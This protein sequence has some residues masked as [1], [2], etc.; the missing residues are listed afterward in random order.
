MFGNRGAIG[1]ILLIGIVVIVGGILLSGVLNKKDDGTGDDGGLDDG[2]QDDGT[3][4]GDQNGGSGQNDD[5]PTIL[6]ECASGPENV[7]RVLYSWKWADIGMDACDAGEGPAKKLF[8]QQGDIIPDLKGKN[9]LA[10]QTVSV[11]IDSVV[12]TSPAASSYSADVTLIDEEGSLMATKTVVAGD[13]LNEALTVDGFEAI[14]DSLYVLALGVDANTG[15]G[16][17]LVVFSRRPEGAFCDATQFSIAFL[18]KLNS[19]L[20][21]ELELEKVENQEVFL[22]KESFNGSF[23]RDFDEYYRATGGFADTPVWYKGAQEGL[24]RAFKDAQ[25]DGG[26]LAVPGKYRVTVENIP[27]SKSEISGANGVQECRA[28]QDGC[29]KWVFSETCEEGFSCTLGQCTAGNN[30]CGGV[31]SGSKRCVPE[32]GNFGGT[33]E[34]CSFDEETNSLEWKTRQQC[35]G[36]VCDE[37]EDGA[38]ACIVV[39]AGTCAE[40][41]VLDRRCTDKEINGETVSVVEQCDY[42]SSAREKNWGQVEICD[43]ACNDG[44]CTGEEANPQ[45][46]PHIGSGEIFLQ[47]EPSCIDSCEVPGTKRCASPMKI[48]FELVS[49]EETGNPFYYLPLE[50]PLGKKAENGETIR[51]GYGV[52]FQA[53]N[54]ETFLNENSVI[55]ASKNSLGKYMTKFEFVDSIGYV[56]GHSNRRELLKVEAGQNGSTRTVVFS[57]S[58]A[59]PVVMEIDMGEVSK[60]ADGENFS[61]RYSLDMPEGSVLDADAL[62]MWENIDGCFESGGKKAVHWDTLVEQNGNFGEYSVVFAG[63]SDTEKN[64]QAQK[65]VP[66]RSKIV[67]EGVVFSPKP[68]PELKFLRVSSGDSE[69]TEAVR[70]FAPGEENHGKEVALSGVPGMRFNSHPDFAE[71]IEDTMELVRNGSACIQLVKTGDTLRA[72]VEWSEKAVKDAALA[73]E[74]EGLRETCLEKLTETSCS[75]VEGNCEEFAE[76]Q[77]RCGTEQDMQVIQECR[78]NV[79]TNCFMWIKVS[80]CRAPNTSCVAGQTKPFCVSR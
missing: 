69:S 21:G 10:G 48:K 23:A 4:D 19:F 9:S 41:Q 75:D 3:G 58:I 13:Y 5:I 22:M 38:L 43:A 24:W 61:V 72:T 27:S 64:E 76:G 49:P 17:M 51:S 37:G 50:F 67:V 18:K 46:E 12:A 20:D 74:K 53:I 11:R 63:P 77:K 39:S 44:E 54:G 57:P 33:L 52:G 80:T 25:F 70:F 7:P 55:D 62:I 35:T 31:A 42:D 32:K 47:D 6:L 34:E 2:G 78:F 45:E 68:V 79:E 66:R 59:T 40:E 1:I 16:E 8:M 15:V 65:P 56:S 60:F 26:E 28:Q 29:K 73:E 14:A 36:K 30:N 71:S